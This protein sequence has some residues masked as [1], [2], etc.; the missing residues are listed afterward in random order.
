MAS[1]YRKSIQDSLNRITKH[2]YH[3]VDDSELRIC[4]VVAIYDDDTALD[5]FGT[6][7]I[8]DDSDGTEYFGVAVNAHINDDNTV[9]LGG[10]YTFPKLQSTIMLKEF[11]IKNH[12]QHVP[13]MFSHVDK[14][15][16]ISNTKYINKVVEVTTSD[17][18]KPY[19]TSATGKEAV[20]TITIDTT[21]SSITDGSTTSTIT[22][23]PAGIKVESDGSD[24]I[25]LGTTGVKEPSVLGDKLDDVLLSLIDEIGKIT[26]QTP[27]GVSS[28]IDTS[29]AWTVLRAKF[30]L[31]FEDFKSQ[32]VELD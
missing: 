19:D 31:D 29:P 22:K 28:S 13:V 25:S 10:K 23:T 17:P 27:A 18:L 7:D 30:V 5:T 1:D 4:T 24:G 15:I 26:I 8:T 16:Q 11:G 14:I 3:K 20:D 12:E 6:I 32:N 9:G 21:T 2:K